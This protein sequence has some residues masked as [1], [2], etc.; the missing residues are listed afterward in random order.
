MSNDDGQLRNLSTKQYI[1]DIFSDQIYI[2]GENLPDIMNA[3]HINNFILA[4]NDLPK[5][6]TQITANNVQITYNKGKK[7][8]CNIKRY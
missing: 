3:I 4:I 2:L 8:S 1:N 6:E 5:V 7:F